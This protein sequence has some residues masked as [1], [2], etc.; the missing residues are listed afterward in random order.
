MATVNGHSDKHPPCT[1]CGKP[2]DSGYSNRW[3]S[4][5][6]EWVWFWRR[7]HGYTNPD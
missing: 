5:S 2:N 1:A 3:C 6:C 7:R 4:A